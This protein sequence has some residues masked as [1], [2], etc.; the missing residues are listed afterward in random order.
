MWNIIPNN[1]KCNFCCLI[2]CKSVNRSTFFIWSEPSWSWSYGSWIYNYLCNQFLSPLMLWVWISIMAR[3][4]I[5]CDKV[6]QRLATGWWFSPA[7][8]I[9]KTD[10]HDIIN[11]NI[12][13]SGIKQTNI[14][15]VLSHF[16]PNV[17]WSMLLQANKIT[18][19]AFNS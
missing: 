8:S 18:K 11:W 6:C 15:E 7:S 2:G 13:E 10:C 5:L 19:I 17:L 12:V 1:N 4:T 9:N 14:Y 3:C 16:V